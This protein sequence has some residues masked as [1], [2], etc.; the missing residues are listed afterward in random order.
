MRVSS[1]ADFLIC[2]IEILDPRG[3]RDDN[4][5]NPSG[6]NVSLKPFRSNHFWG[7]LDGCY[8]SLLYQF[9]ATIKMSIWNL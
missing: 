7:V 8:R 3:S 2:M 1:N 9:A 6:R 4:F 5:A